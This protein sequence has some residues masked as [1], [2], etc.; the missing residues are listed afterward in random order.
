MADII[1]DISR[2]GLEFELS[3]LL[4]VLTHDTF[5]GE[6]DEEENFGASSVSDDNRNPL[7][8]LLCSRWQCAPRTA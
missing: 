7:V 6:I 4:F 3:R 1:F 2:A 8:N 5:P